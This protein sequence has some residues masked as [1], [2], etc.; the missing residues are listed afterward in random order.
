MMLSLTFLSQL[1]T[2]WNQN[3]SPLLNCMNTFHCETEHC[4]E[5]HNDLLWQQLVKF[6]IKASSL[7]QSSHPPLLYCFWLGDDGKGTWLVKST[8]TTIIVYFRKPAY[9]AGARLLLVGAL[10][11]VRGTWR[12]WEH[13]P[14]AEVGGRALI[15]V[16]GKAPWS[17]GH[18]ALPPEAESL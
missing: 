10:M 6:S 18:G 2:Q 3:C 4:A 17:R 9:S 5:F 13:E 1:S 16:Q 14:V 12:A 8:D 7:F 15:G 11:L